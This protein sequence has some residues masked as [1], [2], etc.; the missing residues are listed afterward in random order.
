MVLSIYLIKT[1]KL[2]MP[3][4]IICVTIISVITYMVSEFRPPLGIVSE[5]PYYLFPSFAGIGLALAIYKQNITSAIPFAY[6][7]TTFGVL[8]GADIVR[9]PLVMVGLEEIREAYDLPIGVGSIGGA[10]ALDLVYL[11]GLMAVGPLLFLAPRALRR[12][13]RKITP[14]ESFERKLKKTLSLAEDYIRSGHYNEAFENAFLAVK[15]KI[16]DTGFKFGIDQPP[17]VTLDM[18]QVHPYI[19]NDYWLMANNL[20]N[21]YKTQNDAFRAVITAKHIIR[22]LDRKE[23]RLYATPMQRMV[24]FLLDTAIIISLVISLFYIGGIL[25]VYDL[26]DIFASQN[27]IWFVAFI[28]WLWVA[29]AIYFTIFEGWIG[30]SPGK[31][32]VSIKVVTDEQEK[33]GFMDAFTRNVVRFLDTVLFFYIVSLVM[34]EIYP[35]KQRIGDKVAKTVVLKA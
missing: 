9:I 12:S 26:T 24:A 23:I 30:Q 31:R 16:Q 3:A 5:F 18:L 13:Q 25:G 32:L 8:I 15:M 33:C 7:T 1:K 34:M 22:E 20:K 2:N 19:R 17:Y 6:S 4:I 11:A 28:L 35:K 21:P 10:G 29:Q 14:S 27:F